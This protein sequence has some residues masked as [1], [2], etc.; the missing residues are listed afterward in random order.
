MSIIKHQS[1]IYNQLEDATVPVAIMNSLR[2]YVFFK[3]KK[4]FASLRV[5]YYAHSALE[6]LQHD[7]F[8]ASRWPSAIGLAGG[9]LR[10]RRPAT[11]ALCYRF[12]ALGALPPIPPIQLSQIN[13]SHSA[14]STS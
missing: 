12:A 5:F 6:D 10:L 2:S 8:I 14:L 3:R 1:V 4:A 9:R 7:A 13:F 11:L